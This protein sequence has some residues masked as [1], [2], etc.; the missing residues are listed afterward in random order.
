MKQRRVTC[1]S[2][3]FRLTCFKLCYFVMTSQVTGSFQNAPS[4][5][6]H[7]SSRHITNLGNA[8]KS[9]ESTINQQ[10]RTHSQKFKNILFHGL[11]HKKW[12]SFFMS[13]N[14]DA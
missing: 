1:E 6:S 4:F 5:D 7:I 10:N 8:K 13:E 9:D 11:I 14:N 2:K 3:I 12:F